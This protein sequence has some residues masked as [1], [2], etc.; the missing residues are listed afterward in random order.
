MSN[1]PIREYLAARSAVEQAVKYVEKLS[2]SLTQIAQCLKDWR[3][4]PPILETQMSPP[5]ASYRAT[6]ARILASQWPTAAQFAEVI[7]VY[8]SA[9]DV[10]SKAW[11]AVPKSDRPGLQQPVV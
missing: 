3:H 5:P 2:T 11:D 7:Q 10:Q 6:D 8:H 9:I 1:D 4:A